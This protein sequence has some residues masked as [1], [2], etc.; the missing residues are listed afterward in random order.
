MFS[1]QKVLFSV[2]PKAPVEILECF[3][4][5]RICIAVSIINSI[6]HSIVCEPLAQQAESLTLV[7]L[8]IP[9]WQISGKKGKEEN[10]VFI[11]QG[12][13]TPWVV[14]SA[15]VTPTQYRWTLKPQHILYTLLWPPLL[16]CNT[17]FIFLMKWC[18]HA[19]HFPLSFKKN[20]E[21]PW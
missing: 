18:P 7:E 20:V 9:R 6:F 3:I 12:Q 10:S 15:L 1:F 14:P 11:P 13:N 16:Q 19:R 2:V 4:C 21:Q 5:H 8:K 17:S